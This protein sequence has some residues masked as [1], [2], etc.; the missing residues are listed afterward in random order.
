MTKSHF[1]SSAEPSSVDILESTPSIYMQLEGLEKTKKQIRSLPETSRFW[2]EKL[3]EVC[4]T[5]DPE[6]AARLDCIDALP[7]GNEKNKKLQQLSDD[8]KQSLA[9]AP[10][11]TQKKVRLLITN[12]KQTEHAIVHYKK[13]NTLGTIKNQRQALL[14]TLGEK[15]QWEAGTYDFL[16]QTRGQ[17]NNPSVKEMIK[18]TLHTYEDMKHHYC[19]I[20]GSLPPK[21]KEDARDYIN[22]ERYKYIASWKERCLPQSNSS[23]GEKKHTKHYSL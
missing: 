20:G 12:I 9:K 15:P 22:I 16:R 11:E 8:F 18:Q 2:K 7:E 6:N 17:E 5:I 14:Q 13:E 21:D 19:L 10:E 1:I 4:C 3:R 23:N